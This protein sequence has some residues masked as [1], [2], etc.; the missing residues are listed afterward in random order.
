M[1]G[2]CA[3]NTKLSL[4][5]IRFIIW[6]FLTIGWLGPLHAQAVLKY[7]WISLDAGNL[8]EKLADRLGYQPAEFQDKPFNFE[9]L[10]FFF[11]RVLKEAQNIGRPF[12]SIRLDNIQQEGGKIRAALDYNP[13]PLITFDTVQIT[14]N[15]KTKRLYINRLLRINPGSPFSQKQVDRSAEI[16]KNLPF[17]RLSKAPHLSFQNMEA[18]LH[19]PLDDRKINNLDG[20]LG[21]IPNGGEDNKLLITGRFD[22][23]LYNVG[24]WGRDYSLN[25]QRLNGYSQ[26][27]NITAKEPMLLGSWL[28]LGLT[29][30]L[31]KEDGTFLNRDLRMSLG[32]R[33]GPTTYFSFFSRRQSGNLLAVAHWENTAKLPEIADFKFNN[34][35]VNMLFADL[36]DVVWPR[37]GWL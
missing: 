3:G 11:E 4:F 7:T 27:L 31:L 21:L 2:K 17:V 12:A 8:D 24:G 22:L 26:S 34:H 30:A 9:E 16:L 15:S 14:G 19:L 25:W 33:A 13:G 29:Y 6:F 36:D 5:S 35:G 18:T 1:L 32:Y 20:I 28:D 10:N 37:R 23:A